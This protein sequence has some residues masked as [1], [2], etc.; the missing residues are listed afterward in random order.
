MSYEIE[1]RNHG[2]VPEFGFWGPDTSRIMLGDLPA[3]TTPQFCKYATEA[4]VAVAPQANANQIEQI[5]ERIKW[6]LE[7]NAGKKVRST[8]SPFSFPR[9]L[10]IETISK[11][12]I[13]DNITF[14]KFLAPTS[15]FE[16]LNQATVVDDK[17]RKVRLLEEFQVALNLDNGNIANYLKNP[18]RVEVDSIVMDNVYVVD[19]VEFTRFATQYINGGLL[20]SDSRGIPD[21]AQE[22]FQKLK[23]TFSTG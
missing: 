17:D 13:A 19:C 3:M 18:F 15:F 22:S 8:K 5:K 14:K 21:Y 4:I 11:E 10:H 1:T 9:Q 12:Q 7:V 6:A 16:E 23:Q 2:K 20:G